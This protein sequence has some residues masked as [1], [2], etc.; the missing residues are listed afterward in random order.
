MDA[1]VSL[2]TKCAFVTE[3]LCD[4]GR[5]RLYVC[6]RMARG[7]SEFYPTVR[8]NVSDLD[9]FVPCRCVCSYSCECL[10]A[11]PVGFSY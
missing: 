3:M 7:V 4:R 5:S 10:P 6:V 1:T 11:I 2:D 9:S 8:E